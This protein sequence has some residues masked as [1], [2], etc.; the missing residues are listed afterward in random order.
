MKVNIVHKN[1][2]YKFSFNIFK[3]L[4]FKD[5]SVIYFINFMGYYKINLYDNITLCRF[6]FLY[7]FILLRANLFEFVEFF[8]PNFR[9]KKCG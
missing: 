2:L 1:N 3:Y 5:M 6:Y 8:Y 9:F 7:Y 4:I